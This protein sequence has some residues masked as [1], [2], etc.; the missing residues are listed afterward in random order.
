MA[1]LCGNALEQAAA[2]SVP[3]IAT[4]AEQLTKLGAI[5]AVMTGSG[6]AVFGIF[7]HNGAAR[8]ATLWLRKEHPGCF[9]SLAS[10][11]ERP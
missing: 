7:V 10:P 3:M 4:M 1:A 5:K 8:A 9:V 6:S 2:Q 11:I